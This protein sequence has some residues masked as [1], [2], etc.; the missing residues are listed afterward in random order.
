MTEQAQHQPFWEAENLPAP[1]TPLSPDAFD[2]LPELPFYVELIGGVLIYPHW[3]EDTM[4]AAPIPDHQDIVGNVYTLL[5]DAATQNGGHAAFAPLDVYLAPSDRVQPD[6]IWR[7]PDSACVRTDKHF[8]GAPE[9]VVEVL[10]PSTARR[11]RTEKF[12]LYE[13]YGVREYWI[14][15]PR[16]SLVEVYVLAD[17]AFQRQGAY[18]PTDTFKS[19]QLGV[20]VA[21][22]EVFAI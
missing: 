18:G 14:A 2:A 8:R 1:N 22:R 5:R 6:V 10:S 4:T 13:R 3:N 7:G 15:D 17:G 21:V 19:S 20:D 9:L 16:D 11:D 12:D